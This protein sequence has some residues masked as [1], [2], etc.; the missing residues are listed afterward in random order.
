MYPLIFGFRDVVAGQGF[1]AGVDVQGFALLEREDDAWWMTGVQPAGI[2]DYGA[3]EAEAYSE[4][5]N[6]FREVLFGIAAE[7]ASFE[8]FRAQV[9]ELFDQAEPR[10]FQ[11]WLDARMAIRQGMTPEGEYLSGLPRDVRD[12]VVPKLQL[13]RLDQQPSEAFTPQENAS[14]RLQ[15]AA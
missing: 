3:T 5:R 12:N 9:A 14:D 8:V 13:G 1:L 4:F 6:T 7:A 10:A 2:V 15:A 11:R